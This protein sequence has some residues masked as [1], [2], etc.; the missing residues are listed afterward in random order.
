MNSLS[1][2]FVAMVAT[3][4]WLSPCF[5]AR[6][7]EKYD[8]GKPKLIYNHAKDGKKHG[9]YSE[10][11]ETGRKK[12]QASYKMDVLHGKYAEWDVKGRPVRRCSYRDGKLHGTDSRYED[13]KP[14]YVADFSDGV[15]N[16]TES[17]YENGKPVYVAQYSKGVLHGTEKIYEK[18]KL[19]SE[20]VWYGGNI[21]LFD[22]SQRQIAATMQAIARVPIEGP[23][24]AGQKDAVRRLMTY[25]YV[26]GV[27]WQGISL[28]A[29]M[30]LEALRASQVCAKL[31]RLTHTPQNN[32]G[33][34]DEDFALGKRGAGRSNLA[35]GSKSLSGSVDMWMND[36]DQSNIDRVGHRRWS[37]NPALG[38][39]GFGMSGRYSAHWCMDRS[40]KEIP[41]WEV[42][43][44]PTRGYM[45]S[46]LFK[47]SYAWSVTLNPKHFAAPDR[48]AVKVRMWQVPRSGLNLARMKT[49][50]PI[51]LNYFNVE[52]SGFGVRNAIIFRPENVQVVPGMRY[53]VEI[54]GIKRVG[55][56]TKKK[57]DALNDLL[58]IKTRVPE[59][60]KKIDT[61][62][63]LVEFM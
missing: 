59:P 58:E 7:V 35:M 10:F 23:G 28:D 47:Q 57:R 25:R 62:E 51:E 20:K 32:P 38:K 61:L 34:S 16:G 5:A 55:V 22:R 63:Y 18:G 37:L 9:A 19:L 3:L 33:M 29:Q 52:T 46:S 21:L 60:A 43:A 50:P 12:I 4:M 54:K 56:D 36:S 39:V 53:W 15:L 30:N 6:V 40:R 1:F 48:T 17:R 13:G 49:L 8:N 27:P 42:V 44:F 24:D 14:K 41:D 45:P 26:C 31:G 11:F 2:R